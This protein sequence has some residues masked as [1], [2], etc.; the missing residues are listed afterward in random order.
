M[1]NGAWKWVDYYLLTITNIL[2]VGSPVLSFSAYPGPQ[3]DPRNPRIAVQ[4]TR[5][6]YI[7]LFAQLIITH[8]CAGHCRLKK[9]TW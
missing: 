3:T 1:E 2:E 7:C 8:Y 9:W 4:T 6:S 5:D